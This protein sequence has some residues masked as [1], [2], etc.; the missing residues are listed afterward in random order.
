MIQRIQT[1]Y[2]LLALC[3]TIAAL[4]LPLVSFSTLVSG[5][6]SSTI[7]LSLQGYRGD[8]LFPIQQ[9]ELEQM[10]R[11]ASFAAVLCHAA[12]IGLYR[13]RRWQMR[14]A[15]YGMQFLVIAVI[16]LALESYS[17]IAIFEQ[18]SL[19]LHTHYHYLT[20]ILPIGTLVLAFLGF[21][22]V[23]SDE[24]LVRAADRIR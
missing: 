16:C 1:L 14:M 2:F 8:G 13:H 17:I 4:F 10:L 15:I 20:C 22:A 9:F 5:A 19:T 6:A 7:A 11:I 21:R 3:C 12:A 18:K 24:A 23:R